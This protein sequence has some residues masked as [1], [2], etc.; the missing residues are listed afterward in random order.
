MSQVEAFKVVRTCSISSPGQA[1]LSTISNY[2]SI[3]SRL[4]FLLALMNNLIVAFF[5]PYTSQLPSESSI[6]NTQNNYYTE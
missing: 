1:V 3:W 4:L 6:T 5:Y 2:M